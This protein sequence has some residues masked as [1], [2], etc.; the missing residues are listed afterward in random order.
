ML[1]GRNGDSAVENNRREGHVVVGAVVEHIQPFSIR[2]DLGAVAPATSGRLRAAPPALQL[3][4]HIDFGAH[5]AQDLLRL[6]LGVAQGSAAGE[7]LVF[8]RK[9]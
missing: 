5:F 3:G 4:R 1:P 6:H 7:N 8:L 9:E 2:R